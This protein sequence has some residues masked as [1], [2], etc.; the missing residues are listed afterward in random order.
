MGKRE[1]TDA[2]KQNRSREHFCEKTEAHKIGRT[3][4][5]KY[6]DAGSGKGDRSCIPFLLWRMTL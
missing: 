3:G 6:R 2:G 4:S 5:G 1:Y